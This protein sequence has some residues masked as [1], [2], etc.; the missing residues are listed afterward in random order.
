M[1]LGNIDSPLGKRPESSQRN[2]LAALKKCE[3]IFQEFDDWNNRQEEMTVFYM[4]KYSQLS[5]ENIGI[6]L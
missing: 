2:S 5:M 1:S 4:R 6:Q 3:D